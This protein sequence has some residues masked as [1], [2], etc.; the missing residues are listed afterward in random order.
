V[1]VYRFAFAESFG[2]VPSPSLKQPPARIQIQDVRPQVDCGRYPVKS[3]R[4]D[5]VEVSANVFKDGHDILR[6]VVRYRPVGA[7]KWLERPLEPVGNDRWQGSFEVSEL[8][9]WQF[10]VEAWVDRYA[11][12][13]DELDRKLAAGQRDLAGET[14]EA[15]AL[16]DPGTVEE[17]HAAAAELGAKDRHG[18][19]ALPHPFEVDVERERARFGAWYELFP[20]SWGGFEG[21]R[22]VL[23]RLAELGFDVIYLPPIHPI[24]TTNRKGRNNA[25]AAAK[26]D[27]GSPWAIGGPDGGHDAIHGE[28][29]TLKDFDRLVAEADEHGLEIAL[30]FAIQCSPDH[31]WLQE[32]PEWFNRRP[33]GTLKYAENPPKRYQDIY[34]V[35][36]ESED[37]PGLWE[38][39]RDV[40]LHWC[41]HGV[42]AFRVDNPH[43]KSVPFWEWLIREV[44]GEFPDTVFFAE[45]FTRPAMMTTLAKIGFSQSY[46][47]FTWKNTKGELEEFLRMLLE[48]APFYRPNFFVNTPDILHEYLQEGGRP[49]FEARLVLAATLSP[50]YGIYSGYEHL[51]NVPVA[52]GSEEYLDSEKYE[53]KQRRLDGPLLPLVQ[54]L[55]SIR[56]AEPALQRFENLRL[57]ATH[58][59]HIFAYA[60]G[61]EIA[62][63][64]NLD[65]HASREDVVVVP[66]DI[67]LPEEFPVRDLLTGERY[68]WR[69]GRNYVGLGPGQSHLLKVGA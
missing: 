17:W 35:N 36:F 27:P 66:P 34:N 55:N 67:G 2:T 46:T 10:T 69:V 32:H 47:Y 58:G 57:L 24:G 22:K 68:R 42:R 16:F 54:R 19:T 14:S 41:R 60:K 61:T 53:V 43:T 28:L 65:P 6:A 23:P 13:L 12:L 59:E 18:K 63:A 9:R 4:G 45:A 31:P 39:L 33:D 48:W 5:A 15:E 11:T 52:A 25:L 50:S 64:V 37:W 8:G 30:D 7:R 3:T 21:V 62:V 56:R 26:G 49:A 44:R 40:V 51:E 1:A 20:R 29:G 38:A